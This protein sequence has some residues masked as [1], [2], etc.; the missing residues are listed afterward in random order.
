VAVLTE[1]LSHAIRSM[2]GYEIFSVL[3]CFFSLSGDRYL[4]DDATD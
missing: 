3:F 2:D 4:G 1:I